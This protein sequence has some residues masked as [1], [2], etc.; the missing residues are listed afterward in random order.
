MYD[1]DLSEIFNREGY[2]KEKYPWNFKKSWNT[3]KPTKIF[4]SI[5]DSWLFSSFFER[6]FL[7]KYQDYLLINRAIGGMSNS[8][9][10]NTLQNDLDLLLKNKVDITFLVSFSEV[11]RTTND[12]AFVKP[13]NYKSTHEFF[14]AILKEQYKQIYN[15]IKDYPHYITTG[16]ITNNFNS[17]KSII[18]FCGTSTKNKP[19]GVFT[20]YSNGILEFL[21]DR[22]ELFDF[23]FAEDVKKSLELKEYLSKLEYI[24]ETLHPDYYKPYELFLNEVFSNL[25]KNEK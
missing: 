22:K 13:E 24:D 3:I 11:G 2:D 7:N 25:H 5:G 23:N 20:G 19:Q 1:K 8:L 18:D 6:I 16:F 21:K 9:M 15:I 12:L 10:I 14:G 4:Y 17:N